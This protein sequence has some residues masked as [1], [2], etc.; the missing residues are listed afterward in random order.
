[1]LCDVYCLIAPSFVWFSSFLPSL[2]MPC[3]LWIKLR[4]IHSATTYSRR[5][6]FAPTPIQ[7]TQQRQINLLKAYLGS[8]HSPARKPS[9][10]PHCLQN[11]AHE[12]SGWRGGLPQRGP[13]CLSSFSPATALVSSINS[14]TPWALPTL[15][16][17]AFPHAFPSVLTMGFFCLTL[18]TG[19]ACLHYCHPHSLSVAPHTRPRR[20]VLTSLP[21]SLSHLS[22]YSTSMIS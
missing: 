12:A 16:P 19:K 14:A 13:T 1:M 4:K 6:W 17:L 2:N 9:L 15:G 7:P 3:A 10:S 22:F 21:V 18:Q 5:V 8:C 20:L 11:E